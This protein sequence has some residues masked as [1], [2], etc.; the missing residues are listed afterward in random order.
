MRVD[1]SLEGYHRLLGLD[2]LSNFLGNLYERVALTHVTMS[3][4]VILK[5]YVS[6]HR[7]DPRLAS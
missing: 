7:R 3:V 6:S 5:D 2:G 4:T 1:S